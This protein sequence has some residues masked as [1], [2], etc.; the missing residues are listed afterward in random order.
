MQIEHPIYS[1]DERIRRVWDRELLQDLMGRRAYY[2]AAEMRREE[3]NALWVTLPENRATASL[4]RNWGYYVG[5]DSISAYY[6]ARH[7]E[8]LWQ[9]L[10][11]WNASDSAI[12]CT[13]E[14][15]GWGSMS[16][17]TVT[18]PVIVIAGDGKTARGLWYSM[19]QE[20]IGTPEGAQAWWVCEKQA[21][22]FIRENG[23]WKIW[24]L[25]LSNDFYSPVGGDFGDEPVYYD[26]D[27]NMLR[28]EFGHCDVPLKVHD[29]IFNWCDNYPPMPEPY[30]TYSPR[31]SYAPEGHPGYGKQDVVADYK[32]YLENA[33]REKDARN[34]QPQPADS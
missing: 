15:L 10:R 30:F 27:E 20:T 12:A 8:Q 3:L 28:K 29:E 31:D 9:R 5:M 26:H 21:A 2:D 34:A 32:K 25:I 18:T 11:D 7:E 16:M 14:N 22:D 17:Y 13:R 6:A 23:Q 24:H 1:E 4:G 19:G 33:R